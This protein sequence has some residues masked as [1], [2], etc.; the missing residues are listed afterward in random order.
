MDL[1]G[2]IE[3]LSLKSGLQNL[4]CL[5]KKQDGGRHAGDNVEGI[6]RPPG[7]HVDVHTL[8]RVDKAVV[9]LVDGVPA[10]GGVEHGE[11]RDGEGEE[12]E[13]EQV[14][15]EERPDEAVLDLQERLGE[16]VLEQV[17]V[18]PQDDLA[19]QRHLAVR[20]ARLPLEGLEVEYDQQAGRGEVLGDI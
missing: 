1:I 16:R 3:L 9:R 18:L 12:G 10:V 11:G 20:P 14:D 7:H 4:Y 2:A 19:V 17:L 5:P 8:I 13:E 6:E 15:E